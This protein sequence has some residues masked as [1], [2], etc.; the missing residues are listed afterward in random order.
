MDA[1]T[2]ANF[3]M[4]CPEVLVLVRAHLASPVMALTP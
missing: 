3:A 4:C 1:I 2:L